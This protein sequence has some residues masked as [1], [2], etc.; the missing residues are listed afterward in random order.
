MHTAPSTLHSLLAW[1]RSSSI[2]SL[3]FLINGIWPRPLLPTPPPPATHIF[4]AQ[5]TFVVSRKFRVGT[6]CSSF[7]FY[8]FSGAHRSAACVYCVCM[9]AVMQELSCEKYALLLYIHD[10]VDDD[11]KRGSE[12]CRFCFFFFFFFSLAFATVV[13]A[14]IQKSLIWTAAPAFI[15]WF[16]AVGCCC[17]PPLNFSF[18]IS[19]RKIRSTPKRSNTIPFNII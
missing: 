10:N 17:W 8:C 12:F 4:R 15:V 13:F 5:N 19:S 7:F 18:D 11:K 16:C 1:N 9:L 6:F 14:R 3:S 2:D